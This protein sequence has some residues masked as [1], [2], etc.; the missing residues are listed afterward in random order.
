M[1]MIALTAR[2]GDE[3][4]SSVPMT[5]AVG[6]IDPSRVAARS[7]SSDILCRIDEDTPRPKCQ[8]ATTSDGAASSTS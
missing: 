1:E 8:R 7:G 6:K 5:T 2:L 4:E 3:G